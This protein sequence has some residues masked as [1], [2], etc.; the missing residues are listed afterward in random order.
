MTDTSDS[1]RIL[2]L[3]AQGKITVDDA[4]QLL[5]AIGTSASANGEPPPGPT[6][7]TSAPNR[8]AKWMR[9]T[10]DKTPKDGR[11]RRQVNIRV[12]MTLVR[13]G[14]K[15]GA[16]F[17]HMAREPLAKHLREQG[18]DVDLSKIDLSQIDSVLD[19]IGETTINVDDG[20][21][22]VKISCE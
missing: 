7:G 20:K 16:M 19:N 12:P 13:G 15:L 10:I 11:P 3:L 4:D 5:R 17:P 18:I 22:Q 21:A 14:V 2:D 1:R 8:A 9:I 6:D